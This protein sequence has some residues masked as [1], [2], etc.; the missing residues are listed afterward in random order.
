MVTS[1]TKLYRLDTELLEVNLLQGCI[2][3]LTCL[4]S[5][6]LPAKIRQVHP[7]LLKNF[8]YVI[9]GI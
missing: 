3:D 4:M 7:D 1:K 2:S 6:L 8:F 9:Q 5:C